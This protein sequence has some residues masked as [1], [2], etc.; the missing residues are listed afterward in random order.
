MYNGIGLQTP[1]GSGTSG[2]VQASKFL[3]KPRPSSSAVGGGGTPDLPRTGSGLEGMRKPNKDILEHD[4]K[5]QV[6]LRL[7]VLRDALE[8]QGYTEAEIE[9]RVE[10]ERKAAETEAAAEE[11]RPAAQGKGFRDTHGHHAAARKEN[12]LQTMRGALGLDPE[13]V[14]KKGGL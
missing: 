2:H 10:E 4:R 6:E 12:Q 3:A 13:D 14:Q 9:V 8:E 1:R 7:L 5:R 11:G